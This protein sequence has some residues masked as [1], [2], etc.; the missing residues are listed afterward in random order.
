M[1]SAA[2]RT[3]VGQP[4]LP[5]SFWCYNTSEPVRANPSYILGNT[6]ATWL[7]LSPARNLSTFCSTQKYTPRL[8][9]CNMLQQFSSATASSSPRSWSACIVHDAPVWHS[10]TIGKTLD[11]SCLGRFRR[12]LLWQEP[13]SQ[14]RPL[15]VRHMCSLWSTLP[16]F[17]LGSASNTG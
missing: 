14:G 6:C 10:S 8:S 1:L 3:S 17:G 5:I 7:P 15:N 2:V 13:Q 9:G 12:A 4:A 11:T 16:K